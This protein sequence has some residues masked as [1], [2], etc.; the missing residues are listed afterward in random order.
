[1]GFEAAKKS[2]NEQEQK[3]AELDMLP[4]KGKPSEFFLIVK[5]SNDVP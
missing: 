3:Q 1:L 5:D 4:H 2:K